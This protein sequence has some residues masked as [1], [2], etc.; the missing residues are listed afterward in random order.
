M[1]RIISISPGCYLD[2]FINAGNILRALKIKAIDHQEILLPPVA[3]EMV[4]FSGLLLGA[5]LLHEAPGVWGA[6]LHQQDINTN[7]SDN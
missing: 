1:D 7:S 6:E 4:P 5:P 3:I 2:L